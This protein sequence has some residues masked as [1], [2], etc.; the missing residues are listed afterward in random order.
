MVEQL[1]YHLCENSTTP[2]RLPSATL[3]GLIDDELYSASCELVEVVDEDDE[4]Q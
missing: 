2:I 4:E 3:V 1:H